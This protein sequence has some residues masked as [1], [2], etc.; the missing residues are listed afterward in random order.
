ML[1]EGLLEHVFFYL[2]QRSW[3]VKVLDVQ[4]GTLCLGT[5]PTLPTHPPDL[6]ARQLPRQETV[7]SDRHVLARLLFPVATNRI[8]SALVLDRALPATVGNP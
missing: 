4:L 5:T 2:R 8:N 1:L 3:Q 7:V 6:R